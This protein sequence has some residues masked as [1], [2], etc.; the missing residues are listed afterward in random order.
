MHSK[1]NQS[2]SFSRNFPASMLCLSSPCD[3]FLS[4]TCLN[5]NEVFTTGLFSHLSACT[6]MA[7]FWLSPLPYYADILQSVKLVGLRL[8]PIP[9]SDMDTY[10]CI[11]AEPPPSAKMLVLSLNVV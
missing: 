6:H 3:T 8:E 10:R 11:I 2:T 4:P 7:L 1:P 5:T 9:L